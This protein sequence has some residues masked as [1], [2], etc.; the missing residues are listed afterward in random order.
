MKTTTGMKV[1]TLTVKIAVVETPYTLKFELAPG[2]CTT[3]LMRCC[4][5]STQLEGRDAGHPFHRVYERSPALSLLK[6]QDICCP[7]SWRGWHRGRGEEDR[8]TEMFGKNMLGWQCSWVVSSLHIL[9][10]RTLQGILKYSTAL[11]LKG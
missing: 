11:L 5:F 3:E 4:D 2:A 1:I 10:V 9:R 6:W 7:S 8:K